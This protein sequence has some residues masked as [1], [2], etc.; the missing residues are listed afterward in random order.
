M[1]SALGAVNGFILTGARI[2]YA[3]G[4]ESTLFSLLGRWNAKLGVPVWS[5]LLQG[6]VTIL[7]VMTGSFEKL[8]E[9]TAAAAWLF[10]ALVPLSLI[11]LRHRDSS[12]PRGYRVPFYP[13]VP[14][15][16]CVVSVYM[17]Y[18]SINYAGRGAL[19]GF[20]IVLSGIPVYWISRWMSGK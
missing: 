4:A 18:S 14:I 11:V 9:Y 17:L 3:M 7:L 5:L 8:V 1:L 2:T 15:V 16:F 20:L 6:A 12:T 19:Y 10:F 13:V